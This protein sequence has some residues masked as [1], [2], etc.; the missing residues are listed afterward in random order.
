MPV[1]FLL[2]GVV[3]LFVLIVLPLIGVSIGFSVLSFNFLTNSWV[4]WG[5]IILLG[6]YIAQKVGL[7]RLLR[8]VVRLG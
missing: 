3:I 4:K 2:I 5:L 8:G 6:F 1:P 7:V